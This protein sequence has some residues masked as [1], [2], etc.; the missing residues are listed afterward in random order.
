MVAGNPQCSWASGHITSFTACL[1]VAF[2]PVV[3]ASLSSLYE[4]TS[5]WVRTQPNPEGPHLNQCHLQGPRFQIKSHHA[6]Q[7][8]RGSGERRSPT[9]SVLCEHTHVYPLELRPPESQCPSASLI[10]H[11]LFVMKTP[12]GITGFGGQ[13]HVGIVKP[14]EKWRNCICNHK[15]VF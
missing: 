13:S 14:P 3:A 7:G 4:D 9:R 6:A 15:P 11:I 5:P 1:H 12:Q 8:G 2:F 10:L